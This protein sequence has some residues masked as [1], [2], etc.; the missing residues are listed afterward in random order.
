MVRTSLNRAIGQVPGSDCN[1]YSGG[2]NTLCAKPV[3][4]RIPA[5]GVDDNDSRGLIAGNAIGSDD[6]AMGSE[7]SG[8]S[9]SDVQTGNRRNGIKLSRCGSR[10]SWK[11]DS[12]NDSSEKP[13]FEANPSDGTL[14][15]SFHAVL[16]CGSAIWTAAQP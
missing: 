13:Y 7:F 10:K 11:V 6:F 1:L 14:R 9:S 8:L 16:A 2:P 15:N 12:T 3:C 4:I 5:P